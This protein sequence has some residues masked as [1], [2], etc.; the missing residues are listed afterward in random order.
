MYPPAFI[1]STCFDSVNHNRVLV[2]SIS[3]LL[4]SELNLHSPDDCHLEALEN[5]RL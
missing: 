3:V 2:L 4:Q 5:Q 1:E